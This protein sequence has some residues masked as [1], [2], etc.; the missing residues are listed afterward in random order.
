MIVVENRR[1]TLFESKFFCFALSPIFANSGIVAFFS[2]LFYPDYSES[3]TPVYKIS[4]LNDFIS[5]F[6]KILAAA[7]QPV[8]SV[9][10]QM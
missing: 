7:S 8:E 3:A 9:K 10:T 5:E 1:I 6:V 4:R 2:L